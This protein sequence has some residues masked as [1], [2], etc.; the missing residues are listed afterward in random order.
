MG[1]MKEI[2]I[3]IKNN[4][5]IDEARNRLSRI[6]NRQ[7]QEQSNSPFSIDLTP[8]NR[9]IIAHTDYKGKFTIIADMIPSRNLAEK[10]L[11][12]LREGKY[13][14]YKMGWIKDPSQKQ[15]NLFVSS[16]W[17]HE[18]HKAISN[19]HRKS[20]DN[21]DSLY[22]ANGSLKEKKEK[23][24]M[25]DLILNTLTG[26]CLVA[27]IGGLAIGAVFGSE[28]LIDWKPLVR[29]V[30]LWIILTSGTIGV[31]WLIGGIFRGRF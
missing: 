8:Y 26:F 23:P 30:F 14:R 29:D 2:D 7:A 25:R 31:L 18:P 28:G 27:V 24:K 1:F 6:R 10:A 4:D 21:A 11:K 13:K 17:F 20:V 5:D 9:W 3:A 12:W 16:G 22:E 15:P 19:L